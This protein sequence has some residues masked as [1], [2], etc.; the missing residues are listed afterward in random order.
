VYIQIERAEHAA[1]GGVDLQVYAPR[2][3]LNAALE[4][5]VAAEE[6]LAELNA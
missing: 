2:A 5:A 3:E 1:G 6:Q 4:K